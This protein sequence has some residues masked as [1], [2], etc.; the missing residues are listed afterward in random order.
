MDNLIKGNHPSACMLRQIYSICE[1]AKCYSIGMHDCVYF[2]LFYGGGRR[3]N[4]FHV[5]S[6][7]SVF[8]IYTSS[9]VS[10]LRQYVRII[11]TVCDIHETKSLT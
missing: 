7:N 1:P 10:R 11:A 3:V 5:N 9:R 2:I 6:I 8:H 4:R